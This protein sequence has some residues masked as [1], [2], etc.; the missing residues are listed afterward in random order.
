MQGRDSLLLVCN[1]KRQAQTLFKLLKMMNKNDENQFLL[2]HL[3]AG[4]CPQHRRDTL[5]RINAN[6]RKKRV[7][8]VATQLVEAG[9]DFSFQCV[10]RLMAGLDNLVQT[11]GRCNRSW[12]YK[13][14]CDVYLINL[15]E[16]NLGPLAE[17]KRAQ[18]AMRNTLNTVEK[19]PEQYGN[20]LLS[21]ESVDYY[22]HCL[23]AGQKVGAFDY[24]VKDRET[25]FEMLSKNE[26]SVRQAK[27]S[28]CKFL[29]QAFKT[30]G[31]EFE[32]FGEATTDVIV[33]YNAEAEKLIADLYS[34]RA[35]HDL[36]FLKA[37]LEKAKPY[38]VALYVY[39][40]RELGEAGGLHAA[41]GKPFITVLPGF[42][43]RDTGVGIDM[44]ITERS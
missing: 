29:K 39:Q 23:Y 36:K 9:V 34:E 12:E 6:L 28:V 44:I 20:H 33:P 19:L 26:E 42:Y 27:N 17:I 24:P 5:M 25:L 8:C 4:M 31:E 11:I 43:N 1:T 30:A 38:T 37:L 40:L 18:D 16:E 41:Q 35:E 13:Y 32:V 15:S 3:S 22:Y 21:R 7:V 14:L 10:I 2:F